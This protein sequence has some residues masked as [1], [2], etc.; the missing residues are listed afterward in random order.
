MKEI[1]LSQSLEDYLEA[2][3]TLALSNGE[4]RVKDISQMLSVKMPSVAKAVLE[5]KRLGCVKQVPYGSIELTKLGKECA[6]RVFDRHTLL[7]SFLTRLGV[8]DTI[9]DEDACRME[10]ILSAETLSRIEFFM[11]PVEIKTKGTR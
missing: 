2:I 8:S 6:E 9:A 3:H 1:K 11:N 7:K 5:L 4:A 10:H